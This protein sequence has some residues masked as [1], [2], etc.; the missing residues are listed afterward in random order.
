MISILL[1]KAMRPAEATEDLHTYFSYN[2]IIHKLTSTIQTFVIKFSDKV[3]NHPHFLHL[4]FSTLSQ[5]LFTGKQLQSLSP[6]S[7]LLQ[8]CYYGYT[9]NHNWQ[10]WIFTNSLSPFLYL[11]LNI[12]RIVC[13]HS[14]VFRKQT[15]VIK[16]TWDSMSCRWLSYF[17]SV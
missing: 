2:I 1:N 13:S 8:N 16:Y 15:G 11:L 17:N 12:T 4:T 6:L 10:K 9:T 7:P 5:Y 14:L 3:T